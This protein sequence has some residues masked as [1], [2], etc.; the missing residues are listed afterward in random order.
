MQENRTAYI[1]QLWKLVLE[2]V[3]ENLEP[4]REWKR[5]CKYRADYDLLFIRQM[6]CGN[7]T[8]GRKTETVYI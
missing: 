5:P 8:N 7:A 4:Y 3:A 1:E 2:Y 6:D